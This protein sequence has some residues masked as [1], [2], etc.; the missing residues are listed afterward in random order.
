MLSNEQYRDVVSGIRRIHRIARRLARIPEGRLSV[1]MDTA[2]DVDYINEW[3]DI[4]LCRICGQQAVKMPAFPENPSPQELY[5]YCMKKAEKQAGR[6]RFGLFTGRIGRELL[7]QNAWKAWPQSKGGIGDG[8]SKKRG[9]GG[10]TR[11]LPKRD[12]GSAG[13]HGRPLQ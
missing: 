8:I 12:A 9:C 11:P 10:S 6:I 2:L 4:I 7:T 1:D 3:L 5:R 13:F